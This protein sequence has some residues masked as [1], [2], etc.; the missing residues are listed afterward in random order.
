[1]IARQ[2]RTDALIVLCQNEPWGYLKQVF[3]FLDSSKSVSALTRRQLLTIS[4]FQGYRL[5]DKRYPPGSIGST[6]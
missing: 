6:L 4:F 2:L 1:M 3:L 5:D